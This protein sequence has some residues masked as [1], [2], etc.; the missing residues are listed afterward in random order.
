MCFVS[1]GPRATQQQHIA[2]LACA[3]NMFS[4]HQTKPRR[5]SLLHLFSTTR[6]VCPRGAVM[7]VCVIVE[8]VHPGGRF[9]GGTAHWTILPNQ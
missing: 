7:C 8:V 4:G 5:R 6:I 1:H 2:A 3:E 9:E